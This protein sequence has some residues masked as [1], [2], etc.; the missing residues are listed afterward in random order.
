MLVYVKE[1][2]N[3]KENLDEQNI[4]NKRLVFKRNGPGLCEKISL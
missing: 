2:E 4:C 1:T 3:C